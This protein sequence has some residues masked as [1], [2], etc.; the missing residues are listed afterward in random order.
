MSKFDHS[1]NVLPCEHLLEK[2]QDEY[3]IVPTL[4]GQFDLIAKEGPWSMLS[5]LTR[6]ISRVDDNDSPDFAP[7]EETLVFSEILI[8]PALSWPPLCFSPT[9]GHPAPNFSTHPDSSQ[10]VKFYIHFTF[11]KSEPVPC[12]T[13]QG[14]R[15]RAGTVGFRF[16][17]RIDS[18]WIM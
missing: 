9:L 1:L 16:S 10:P 2:R 13:R 3:K 8:K 4:K 12:C 18:C 5:Y 17:C 7:D 14:W 11:P 6:W 15:C